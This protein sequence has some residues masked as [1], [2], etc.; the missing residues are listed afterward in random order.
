MHVCMFET[1][2]SMHEWFY[3]L[4]MYMYVCAYVH[5]CVYID[6]YVHNYVFN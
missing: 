1:Y 5:V 6:M 3:Y 4:I 2:A